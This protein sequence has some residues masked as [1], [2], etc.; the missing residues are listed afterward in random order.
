M[1]LA[2][3]TSPVDSIPGC[4]SPVDPS[5]VDPIPV[6]PIP[7]DPVPV[8]PIPVDPIPDGSKRQEADPEGRKGP[9]RGDIADGDEKKEG[10]RK[11]PDTPPAKEKHK[12]SAQTKL[13]LRKAEL[14]KN[15]E[16]IEI[17]TNLNSL[18]KD[19][20]EELRQ[21][22]ARLAEANSHLVRDIQQTDESMA[23]E[24]RAL[25]Q[26]CEALQRAKAKVQTSHQN[27]LDTARAELQEMEKTMEKSL[28]KL[29][30]TLDE[31]TLKVQVLQEELGA[32]QTYM[33]TQYP[34]QA[35]QIELLQHS[36]QGL[37]EQH[38]EERDK[39]ERM[40]KLNLEELE[41]K[42]R[43]EQEALIQKIV[44]ETLLHQDSL[45][46]MVINNHI[47]QCKILQQKEITKD[48]EEE[49]GELKRSIQTLRQGVRDPREV[50]FGDVLLL[51]ARCPPDPEVTLSIPREGTQLS[52]PPD[53]LG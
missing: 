3:R 35:A 22:G 51:R 10:K 50:I 30:Q 44:E 12:S 4:R 21:R 17:I 48:L 7:V 1:T 39:I 26:Q 8:Y 31:V 38:Q 34:A 36:I 37:K 9:S 28:G 14:A 18:R 52:H 6:Y 41:E 53:S 5:P 25:L 29:Q 13:K 43:V 16:E 47:L 11:E 42:I 23:R 45:K 24:A 19:A 40:G 2:P 33:D 20:I 15:L 46:Q 49:V 32:L 27:R